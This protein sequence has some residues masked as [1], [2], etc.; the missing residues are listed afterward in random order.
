M[1][2]NKLVTAKEFGGEGVGGQSFMPFEWKTDQPYGFLVH[3]EITPEN[4]STS[5]TLTVKDVTA[6]KWIFVA[7]W[8]RPEGASYMT[9][10]YSFV[11]NYAGAGKYGVYGGSVS[12]QGNFPNS[13][14]VDSKT[15]KW[16]EQLSASIGVDSTGGNRYRLDFS[17]GV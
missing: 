16:V 13:W 5:Y 8:S 9:W 12:R 7:A 15:G 11:E 4:K 2:K 14:Y 17:G 10:W 6:D 3:A 1:A